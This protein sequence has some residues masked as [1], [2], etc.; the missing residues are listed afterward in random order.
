[1][2]AINYIGAFILHL[3]QII[4][5]LRSKFLLQDGSGLLRMKTPKYCT[6]RLQTLIPVLHASSY[7]ES[8]RV[9]MM[10]C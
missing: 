7:Q 10:N 6:G 5:T 3:Y 8:N 2:S 9:N 1:M 4:A